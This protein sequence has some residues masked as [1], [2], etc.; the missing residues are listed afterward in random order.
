MTLN[1]WDISEYENVNLAGQQIVIARASIGLRQDARWNQYVHDA[2][3]HGV[4]LVGYHFLNSGKLGATAT[5]QASFAYSVIGNRPCMLDVESNRGQSATV[6]EAMEW[7]SQYR[8]LGGICNLVYFPHWYWQQLGNPDL[9]PLQCHLVS[10]NYTMY[11]DNGPGWDSYGGLSP[12]QWQYTDNPVDTNAFKGTLDE[13]WNLVTGGT[14][15]LTDLE[16][17]MLVA[18]FY[19]LSTTAQMW[20]PKDLA[21]WVAKGGSSD[22]WNIA[23]GSGT[24]S[25]ALVS[26][27]QDLQAKVAELQTKIGN[28][29]VT[30]TDDQVKTLAGVF[31]PTVHTELA[32]LGLTVQP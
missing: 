23:N 26:A 20:D 17:R 3:Q 13:Y 19:W 12:I 14:D 15:M 11:S 31:G 2:Q 25:N 22:T 5:T 24:A 30:L 18:M 27:V 10:S 21:E 28:A 1:F 6:Q 8:K 29:T 32:K 7:L 16:H 4:K 9:R